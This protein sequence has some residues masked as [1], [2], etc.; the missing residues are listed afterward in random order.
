M[1]NL[2]NLQR[3]Q[4]EKFNP[5]LESLL[6]SHPSKK[7]R[8]LGV[9]WLTG[10][11]VG[12]LV[13]FGHFF[14][15]GNFDMM[16]QD[17]SLVTGPRLE[18]LQKALQGGQLPLHI[19]D[20]ETFHFETVRYFA[21]ADSFASP[22]YLLLKWMSLPTF[23]LVNIW[24]LY[25]LGFAG[26]LV[27][28]R[29]LR[30]SLISF[31]ALFLLFNFNGGILAHYSVGHT[32]WGGYFLLPWFAWLVF[33][34]LEGDHSWRW[35]TLMSI[36]I[37]AVWLQGS[38]HHFVWMLILLMGIGIFIPRT[39]W[40][41]IKTGLVTFLVCA[42]RLLPCIVG[43]SVY[44]MS[45]LN[46]YP[47]LF[48][49]WDNLVNLPHSLDPVF[50]INSSLGEGLGEWELASFIGLIGGLFLVYFGLYRGLLHRQARYRALAGPLGILLLLSLGPVSK[51]LM[52]LPIPLVQGERA[53][54]RIFGLVLAF[55]LILA[56]EGLQRWLDST[57]QKLA[58]LTGCALALVFIGVE[59][60][61]D[62]LIWRV[63]NRD[64]N[65]WIYF[66]PDK[67]FVN[68]NYSDKLYIGLIGAGLVISIVSIVVLC[69]LSWRE[70]RRERI[71]RRS[72]V[73]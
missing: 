41:V 34:L 6:D 19:S 42:F 66:N 46:G 68:N 31:S 70:Y 20:A 1:S 13:L 40:T 29:K 5:A 44:K 4:N 16:Y 54:T 14:S 28:M 50:Y 39:F 52:A 26:L 9:L 61:Q 59:L 22:Q 3:F 11:F 24:L 23:S 18:F 43:Y 21:V 25:S 63:S 58:Y 8:W 7:Y 51:L 69:G 36:V 10:L 2:V 71:S 47:S 45:F 48:S 12:G 55:G 67:W 64:P 53:A 38:Y 33:R 32:N 60:W 49:I 17:W 35:T 57:P 72:P 37:F 56:A 27:L 15:W 65:F 73:A 62:S 30:L